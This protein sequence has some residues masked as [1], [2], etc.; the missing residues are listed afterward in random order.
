MSGPSTTPQRGKESP[1]SSSHIVHLSLALEHTRLGQ[2]PDFGALHPWG[3]SWDL[4]GV[5]LEERDENQHPRTLQ[6]KLLGTTP[7]RGPGLLGHEGKESS[8]GDFAS[9]KSAPALAEG[10]SDGED[11]L[12]KPQGGN[13]RHLSLEVLGAM[14]TGR[15]QLPQQT[16]LA[17]RS[18]WCYNR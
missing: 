6:V 11:K 13:Q 8:I 15:A 14:G 12:A 7:A 3:A 5:D 1:E 2:A 9:C 16:G 18:E 17:V 10:P 4:R